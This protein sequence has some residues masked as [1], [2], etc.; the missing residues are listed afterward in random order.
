[1]IGAIGILRDMRAYEQVVRD[2]EESRRKL[3]EANQAKDQFLATLSHELRT[4]L[5]AMLGWVR[6]LP[7]GTLDEAGAARAFEVIERNIKLQ[8]QLIEDL[9]DISR[10]ISGKLRLEMRPVDLVAVIEAALEAVPA[11]PTPRASASRSC[12]MRRRG[13]LQADPDRLQQVVWNLLS[14]A[15]KFTPNRGRVDVRLERVGTAGANRRERYRAAASVP[16]SCPTCSTGSAR[17]KRPRTVG[18]GLGLAIVQHIVE[19][20]GGAVRAESAGEGHGAT[21]TVELPLP[22]ERC[23][24]SRAERTYEE[25]ESRIPARR[26]HR[27]AGPGRGRR[28]RRARAP[29]DDSGAGPA[30]KSSR[31]VGRRGADHASAVAAGRP[32]QRHRDAGRRR[33]CADPADAGAAARRGRARPGARAHGVRA[34]GGRVHALEAGFQTHVAKPVDPLELTALIGA[35]VP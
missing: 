19:L 21:F 7:A 33:I 8:V 13:P 24:P 20:H 12:S 30:P 25:P 29:D 5:N 34:V 18:L 35:L 23:P 15:I 28:S 22:S 4:P 10:I 16:S 27:P 9:L 6:L 31:R 1:M 17:P 14:N 32:G 3:R 11:W 2:L 26:S